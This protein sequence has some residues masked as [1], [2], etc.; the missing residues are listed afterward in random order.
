MLDTLSASLTTAVRCHY[1]LNKECTTKLRWAMHCSSNYTVYSG[2]KGKACLKERRRNE[3]HA[4]F[5]YAK[6]HS[7]T[8]CYSEYKYHL[9]RAFDHFPTFH[10]SPVVFLLLES[11]K[12]FFLHYVP[13]ISTY[14][15]LQS[16]LKSGIYPK[17]YVS[18]K[19]KQTI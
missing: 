14:M 11:N 3:H 13:R 18:C 1:R 16:G 8:S 10:K 9:Q 7:S 19:E 15:K 12:C 17:H 5:T 2:L 4:K 6:S